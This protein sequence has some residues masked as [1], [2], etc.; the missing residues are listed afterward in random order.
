MP[1][2]MDVPCSCVFGFLSDADIQEELFKKEAESANAGGKNDLCLESLDKETEFA[3]AGGNNDRCLDEAEF[4]GRED[5]GTLLQAEV[6]APLSESRGSP[7][8]GKQDVSV[9]VCA[10]EQRRAAAMA[11]VD[12]YPEMAIEV[13]HADGPTKHVPSALKEAEDEESW[14]ELLP[15]EA[16]ASSSG[17][18][19]SEEHFGPSTTSSSEDPALIGR[20]E[21]EA[22]MQSSGAKTLP[23]ARNIDEVALYVRKLLSASGFASAHEHAMMK[24]CDPWQ[25]LDPALYERLEKETTGENCCSAQETQQ[26]FVS[27]GKEKGNVDAAEE[28]SMSALTCNRRLIFDAVNDVLVWKL[29]PYRQSPSPWLERRRPHMPSRPTGQQLIEEILTEVQGWSLLARNESSTMDS[30]LRR[31]ITREKEEWS[32]FDQESTE[33]GCDMEEMILDRLL[34]EAVEDFVD[35]ENKRSEKFPT[36]DPLLV[37]V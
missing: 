17:T 28:V 19:P 29:L 34:F 25:P 4:P 6:V 2:L 37:G 8:L 21:A 36:S 31:E 7:S 18:T 22:G 32:K 1:D 15:P 10:G 26:P 20:Q 9:A 35:I 24:W 12:L 14:I 27:S 13:K 11:V 5:E 30:V 23:D 3:N 33:I 16:A